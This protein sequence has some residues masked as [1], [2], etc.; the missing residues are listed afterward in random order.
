MA[1][2]GANKIMLHQAANDGYRGVYM[3]CFDGPDAGKGFVI[4]SNGDNPAV[5]LQGELCR[6]LLKTLNMQGVD[7]RKYRDQ[8]LKLNVEGVKQESI[9]NKGLKDLVISAFQP[10]PCLRS[11]L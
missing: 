7:Y 1:Q 10:A 2:A 6:Q 5:L 8:D 9:V 4:L 11:R 3:L